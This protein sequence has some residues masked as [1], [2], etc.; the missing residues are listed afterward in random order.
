[1]SAWGPLSSAEVLR[2]RPLRALA[3][4]LRERSFTYRAYVTFLDS[5]AGDPRCRVAPLRRLA[6]AEAGEHALVGLRHDVDAR[7]DSARA[8]ARLEAERGLAATYFVLHTASYYRRDEE[9]A[10]VLRGLQS[11]GHEIGLHNDSLSLAVEGE[12]PVAV[13]ERE[14]DWLRGEGID[15]VGVA[16]HGSRAA[17]RDRFLNH[18]VFS[19]LPV[20]PRFPNSA[21]E[22]IDAARFRRTTLR[23]LGL[24][25][26]ADFLGNERYYADSYFER[27]ARW[28]PGRL[29][30]SDLEA[31]TKTVVLVH[32]CHWDASVSAKL[33]RALARR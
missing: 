12:D 9:L 4:P 1:V 8:I 6:G 33:R 25:Y 2:R 7:L 23:S 5:L 20:R 10:G 22:P 32:P 31:G 24:E 14:L 30:A 11:L 29:R 15:V 26:D 21:V 3:A 18:Q 13:L 16:G 28:H 17:H 27:G 19:D